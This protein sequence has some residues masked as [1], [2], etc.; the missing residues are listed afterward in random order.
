LRGDFCVGEK[1]FTN[2]KE[3]KMSFDKEK[4]KSYI[5]NTKLLILA[6]IDNENGQIYPA[7][8]TI[9][10]FANDGFTIYFSTGKDSLKV[11]QIENNPNVAVLFQQEGQESSSFRNVTVI[12]K[13]RLLNCED[14]LNNAIEIIGNKNPKFKERIK[15]S[16]RDK[17]AVFKIEPEVVKNLD[18]SRGHGP[19]AIEKFK[20]E[21][22][23]TKTK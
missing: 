1:R 5:G 12:G 23:C 13:A 14:A 10:S 8:R 17:I 9:G 3:E 19:Q 2:Q 22:C 21:A 6:T 16:G 20:I 11:K 4:I 18:F 7:L 15:N